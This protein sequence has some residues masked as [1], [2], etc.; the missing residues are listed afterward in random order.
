M[1]NPVLVSVTDW[2][3]KIELILANSPDRAIDAL[4]ENFRI[5]PDRMKAEYVAALVWKLVF[6]RAKAKGSLA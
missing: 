1:T 6:L 5:L 2:E 3:S 4:M